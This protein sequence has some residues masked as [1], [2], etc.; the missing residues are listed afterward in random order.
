MTRW[1][2]SDLILGNTAI[3]L[4][5]ETVL[6]PAWAFLVVQMLGTGLA[7]PGTS[8]TGPGSIGRRDQ[9]QSVPR[10]PLSL[11][12]RLRSEERRVGKECSSRRAPDHQIKTRTTT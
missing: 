8:W 11:T 1:A 5:A 12:K 10:L 3:Y 9:A 7:I 4:N 6:G 2:S